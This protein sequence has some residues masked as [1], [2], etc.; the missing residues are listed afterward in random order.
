LST[1]RTWLINCVTKLTDTYGYNVVMLAPFQNPG[2][3][4]ASWQALSAKAWVGI[5][6]YLSGTEVMNS[7]ADNTARFNWA[8][9]RRRRRSS[10]SPERAG[11][12][13]RF[14]QL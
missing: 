6:C 11:C 3:N 12:S 13:A 1:Y 5:E 2:A 7:G 9:S 8:F 14:S 10:A 4:D